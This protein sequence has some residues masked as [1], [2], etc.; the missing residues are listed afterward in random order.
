MPTTKAWRQRD[1]LTGVALFLATAAFTLWQNSRVGVLWDLSFLLDSSYRFSLGQLPYKTLPFPHPPLTFLLHAAII[2]IFGRVYFPHILC[3]TLEAGTA[4]LLT[5]RILLP[6]LSANPALPIARKEARHPGAAGISVITSAARPLALLLA[7]P[8]TVLGIYA[9]YPHPIYDSDAILA[10]LLALYLLQRPATSAV[11]NFLAGAA[12]VLPLFFKQNIG[13]IFLFSVLACVATIAILRRMQRTT[14]TPQ[15]WCIAGTIVASAAALL[16]LQF[17]VGLDN[18]L[19]W[20]IT[21]ARQRRLPGVAVMLGTYHQTSLLWTIPAAIGALVLLRYSENG[22]PERSAAKSKDLRFLLSHPRLLRIAAILLF[23]APFLW[24]IATLPFTDDPSDRADQLLSL[25]P[26]LL[27]LSTA[28]AV[29]NLRPS[30]L[31]ANP[32]LSTLFPVILLA[33]IHGTFL[34]QQLWGSTYALWSLLMLL[35]AMLLTQIPAIAR[36]MALIIT[37]T[38]ILC[39]SRYATSHERLGYIHLDGPVARASAPNLRGLA[40]PGPWIPAF[41]EL[42]R[43]TNAEIPASDGI[44]LIP[45]EDPF[46]FATGRRPQFPIL[47]FDPTTDPYTPQQTRDEARAHNIRW[48]ILSRDTQLTASPY[49][50]LPA[51]TKTLLPDF[52]PYRTLTNYIIYRRK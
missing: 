30:N 41:E 24:T 45:G 52:A 29:W 15:L 48:L 31:R 1:A 10:V 26:H 40:T 3:A 23:A 18:Y 33:T 7:A 27:V 34:S 20:T 46:F 51:I 13:L 21:F 44:L 9:I 6:L 47:L 25:W 32:T 38:F 36:P 28:F 12:C 17:T 2:H 39:G 16:A 14:I 11:A 43:V 5:W 8:L 35:I 4:T 22:H 37:A 19:H 50:A 49:D 42:V